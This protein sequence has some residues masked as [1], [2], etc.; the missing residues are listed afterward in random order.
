MFFDW[1][2]VYQDFD[3]QLPLIAGRHFIAVDTPTGEALGISQDSLKHVGSFSTSITIRISGNRLTVDGNP[4]R[5]D[6]LENLFGFST[7]DQCIDV[8]NRIL[9]SYGLPKFTK[10]TRVW[11][12]A[13]EGA[14]IK[15]LTD[16]AV[17]QEIHI[18][19]NLTTGSS[20]SFKYEDNLQL[21][22][23]NSHADTYIKAI[24]TLSYRHSV[25]RLHTNGK[26][27]D[28]LTKKGQGSTLIYPSVYNKAYELQ[29][30][31]LPKI[32]RTHGENSPEYKYL[33]DVINYCEQNGVIRFEQKLKSAYLRANNL[34]FYGLSSLDK[35][36]PLHQEFLNLHTKL[37]VESMSL[38]SITQTLISNGICENTKSANMTTLYAIQWMHGHVFDLNKK[39]VQT[40]RARLRK[41]GIDI[42]N[43]CDVT[44]FSLVT[45]KSTKSITVGT[46]VAPTWYKK[47]ATSHLS[48][49]A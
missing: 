40:H 10:A 24:S 37:Q 12:V 17:F 38:E 22:L 2:K 49:A 42:A 1:L 31:A 9:Q 16:G 5:V 21:E 46:L 30:H 13:G 15:T 8:Y 34:R 27:C 19:S 29:L 43:P 33:Q 7:I 3:H 45:V 6:R 18:T 11:H 28:W 41:I 4:S 23:F 47:P 39:Q 32:K 48:I 44:K 25:P 26:T 14:K 35:L 36:R 20:T